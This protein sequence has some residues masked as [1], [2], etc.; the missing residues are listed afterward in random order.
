MNNP[1]IEGFEAADKFMETRDP[2]F[3]YNPYEQNGSCIGWMNGFQERIEFHLKN[4]AIKRLA[5]NLS[6]MAIKYK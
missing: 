4:D 2:L 6:L 3:A 1:Y 5:I